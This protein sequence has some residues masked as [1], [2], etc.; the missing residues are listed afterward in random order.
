MRVYTCIRSSLL[1]AKCLRFVLGSG[2]G[3]IGREFDTG[4]CVYIFTAHANI[5]VGSRHLQKVCSLQASNR[6]A[7]Y[8]AYVGGLQLVQKCAFK[9]IYLVDG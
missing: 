2:F 3:V 1:C 8:D 4:F 5:I 9:V 6:A 7:V